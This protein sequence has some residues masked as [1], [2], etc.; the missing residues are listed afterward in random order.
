MKKYHIGTVWETLNCGKIEIIGK[1]KGKVNGYKVK[2]LDDGTIFENVWCSNIK[3]GTVDNPNKRTVYGV[4]YRG[5]GKWKSGNGKGGH[6]KE[7]QL[8]TQML[9]RCYG[10]GYLKIYTTYKECQVDERW[11]NFQNF[12]EDLPKLE[13][14]D[15]W[16]ELGGK[17]YHL[18]KDFKIKG[19]KIYSL[20]TCMFLD[21]KTNI[22]MGIKNRIYNRE[23]YKTYKVY[24][25][26][27]VVFEGTNKEIGEFLG[28]NTRNVYQRYYKN[29]VKDGFEIKKE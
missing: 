29:I 26:N 25:N 1:E 20:E 9:H 23:I 4:G 16:L 12:C 19:N 13:N 14:Y 18:D 27:E 17:F 10:E 3:K 22:T 28:T 11:H 15:K 24:K 2:F 8:W 5:I 6:S 21:A 7:Y